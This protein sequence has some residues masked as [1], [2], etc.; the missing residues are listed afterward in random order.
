[1][2]QNNEY[3]SKQFIIAKILFGAFF[4]LQV[5]AAAAGLEP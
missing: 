1:M 5:A 2:K 3:I 4:Y